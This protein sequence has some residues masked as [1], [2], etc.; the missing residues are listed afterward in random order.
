MYGKEERRRHQGENAIN[1]LNIFCGVAHEWINPIFH[2]SLS[3]SLSFQVDQHF[4]YLDIQ[5]VES[6]KPNQVS[7]QTVSFRSFLS[8]PFR[9]FFLCFFFKGCRCALASQIVVVLS[10]EISVSADF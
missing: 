3:L 6:R 2:Y 9:F 8:S 10:L 1:I 7:V 5:G 4:H